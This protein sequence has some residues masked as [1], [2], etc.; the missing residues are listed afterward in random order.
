MLR[1]SSLTLALLLCGAVPAASDGFGRTRG[2][3]WGSRPLLGRTVGPDRSFARPALQVQRFAAERGFRARLQLLELTRDAERRGAE[4][5]LRRRGSLRDVANHRRR[6]DAE[7]ALDALSLRNQLAAIGSRHPAWL[8]SL[9][10]VTRRV[11]LESELRFQH[12]RREH[13]R[14]ERIAEIVREVWLREPRP[15]LGHP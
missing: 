13:E 6:T 15:T 1:T 14:R 11:L 10:P 3:G 5:A 4:Y 7:D 8:D 12:V 2:G 9:A